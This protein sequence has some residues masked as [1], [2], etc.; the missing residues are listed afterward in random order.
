M[1]FLL[2]FIYGHISSDLILGSLDLLIQL[3]SVLLGLLKDLS[4]SLS[5]YLG[6]IILSLLLSELYGNLLNCGQ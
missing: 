6:V 3:G 1:S 2:G 4:S 5:S